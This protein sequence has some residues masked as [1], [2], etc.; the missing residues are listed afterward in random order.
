MLVL[1]KKEKESFMAM[2]RVINKTEVQQVLS[3]YIGDLNSVEDQLSPEE[4]ETL[5]QY[6][7]ARGINALIIEEHRKKV[8]EKFKELYESPLGREIKD[9]QKNLGTLGEQTIQFNGAIRGIFE[10]VKKRKRSQPTLKQLSGV[11]TNL[12]GG[13]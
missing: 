12:I 10:V 9:L 4:F 1:Q 7:S 11:L 6:L 2:T 8:R 13:E 3:Q 5:K